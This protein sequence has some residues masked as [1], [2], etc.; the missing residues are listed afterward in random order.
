MRKLDIRYKSG[1]DKVQ[2]DV[3]MRETRGVAKSESMPGILCS[4]EEEPCE[5]GKLERGLAG[6][7]GPSAALHQ[8]R[9][10]LIT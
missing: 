6:M 4:A 3:G 1:T 9:S 2:R 5:P 10:L 8:H 7:G